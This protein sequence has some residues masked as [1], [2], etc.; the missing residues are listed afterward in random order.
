M[1]KI[2]SKSLLPDFRSNFRK[3]IAK[4]RGYSAMGF[5]ENLSRQRKFRWNGLG[6]LDLGKF[7]QT[8]RGFFCSWKTLP[9][10]P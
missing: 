2:S 9:A 8:V 7:P 3:E 4:H 10:E 6:Q 5:L 1:A